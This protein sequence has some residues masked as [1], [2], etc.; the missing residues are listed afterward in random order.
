MGKYFLS[1][2]LRSLNS[3]LSRDSGV[4]DHGEKGIQSFLDQHECQEMCEGLEMQEDN[5]N[6]EDSSDNSDNDDKGSLFNQ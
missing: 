3:L 4:G 6:N 2:H 1:C 5:D